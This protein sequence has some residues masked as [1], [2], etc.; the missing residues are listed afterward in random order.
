MLIRVWDLPTRLF[1]WALVISITGSIVSINLDEVEL[2]A[3]FG[4]VAC[5]LVIFRVLW[6][7][8]GSDTARF[9]RFVR[10]PGAILAY[11][12][13]ASHAPGHNPLGA[14]SVL[15]L[16]AVVAA[17][18]GTGIFISQDDLFFDAPWATWIGEAGSRAMNERHEILESLLYILI[19]LHLCA[20]I[21]YRVFKRQDLVTPMVTGRAEA[22]AGTDTPRL[23]PI[24]LALPILGLAVF[25]AGVIFRYWVS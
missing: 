9:V 16:L 4:F 24:W 25:L 12:Q 22:P 23:Q 13:G 15:A 2:H 10:G 20:I 18:V 19:A 14:L 1:H 7:L 11:L 8:V 17:Q 3:Q 5:T 21:A 6:G